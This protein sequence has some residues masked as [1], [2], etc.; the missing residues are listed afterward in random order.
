MRDAIFFSTTICPLCSRQ[1]H[2]LVISLKLTV[3]MLKQNK[4]A[5]V[6]NKLAHIPIIAY[7]HKSLGIHP[8]YSSNSNLIPEAFVSRTLLQ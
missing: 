1:Y 8:N 5:D 2:K 4:A 3:A 6:M 7:K